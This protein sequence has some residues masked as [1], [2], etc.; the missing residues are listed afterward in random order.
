MEPF[1]GSKY[2]MAISDSIEEI[3]TICTVCKK[4]KAIVNVRLLNNEVLLDGEQIEIGDKI[5][6]PMCRK[7]FNNKKI[8]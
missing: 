8:K 6:Q 3:K 2:L 4:R 1:E 5:Y 7:C